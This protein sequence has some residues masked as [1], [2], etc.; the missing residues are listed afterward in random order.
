MELNSRTPCYGTIFGVKV[1]L[2]LAPLVMLRVNAGSI[3]QSNQVISLFD[4]V[5]ESSSTTSMT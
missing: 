3:R 1:S 4:Y 2:V 5:A